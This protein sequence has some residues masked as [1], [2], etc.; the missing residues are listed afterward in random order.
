MQI[1]EFTFK[2]YKDMENVLES[3]TKQRELVDLGA[4]LIAWHSRRK[5]AKWLLPDGTIQMTGEIPEAL[6][7]ASL[8]LEFTK[9]YA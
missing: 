2:R 5:R 7:Y 8:G 9:E 1:D 4:R 3:I 6:D